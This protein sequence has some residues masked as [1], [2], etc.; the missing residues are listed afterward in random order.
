MLSAKPVYRGSAWSGVV[1]T[2]GDIAVRVVDAGTAN[3]WR[4]SSSCR[5]RPDNAVPTGSLGATMRS[6]GG[7]H[8]ATNIGVAAAGRARDS[9]AEYG[10]NMT[11]ASVDRNIIP[12]IV[13]VFNKLVQLAL[14][15]T[16]LGNCSAQ[17]RTLD[18]GGART[19]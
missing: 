10:I 12:A 8:G 3:Q 17:T 9:D 11:V 13:T 16:A 4:G 6:V 14:V 19:E 5:V 1:V 18:H 7:L 2:D 15:A